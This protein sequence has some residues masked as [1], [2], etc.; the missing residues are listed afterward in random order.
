VR[1]V[2]RRWTYIGLLST[3]TFIN[4]LDRGSLAVALPL[5]SRDL[6]LTPVQQGVVLSS[7]F[8]TYAALQIPVG[9]LVDRYEIKRLYAA[10]FAIWSL[11]AAATGL[12][13]GLAALIGCRVL[14]GLGESIYLPGGLKVVGRH[15]G[16]HEAAWPA[17]LFDLGAKLGLAAGTAV[18][19]WLL[20]RFG[21]RSLFFRTGLVGLLWLVPWLW[22]YPADS[23]RGRGA[24]EP[25]RTATS[26]R[27]SWPV[28][29]RNRALIGMSVGF[30]CWDYF[31]YF[32]V[33]WLPSYLYVVR[34][35]KLAHVAA[36]G[37]L[38]FVIFALAEAL[39]AWSAGRLV[40][41]GFDLLGVTKGFIAAGFALGLLVIPAALVQSAAAS[42]GL[43]FAASLAGLAC[44][45][46]LALPAI[47]ASYDEVA[48]WTGVQ[49]FVGNIGGVLAPVATGYLIAVRGSY[50]PGFLVV[51]AILV[52]GIASYVFIVPSDRGVGRR[53]AER[54]IDR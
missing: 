37:S 30:F 33:S 39:G 6:H 14:L 12:V 50:V 45:N 32:V 29:L 36:A 21:W 11:A 15:F 20:I 43:L 38:P 23:S 18:D 34:H 17:G 40:R 47:C 3:A 53:G 25:T 7:F 13:G 46:M 5:I 16:S 31:W 1:K 19:V 26:V 54:S 48:L 51:A 4:Y 27:T 2:G 24:V 41:H 22:L 44:G 49:N 42:I 52:A 10:A 28:L 8:W 35:V 9:W